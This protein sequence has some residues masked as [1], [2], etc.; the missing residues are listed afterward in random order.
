MLEIPLREGDPMTSKHVK[1]LFPGTL[2]STEAWKCA[3][4]EATAAEQISFSP[5]YNYLLTLIRFEKK[6][7]PFILRSK[8]SCYLHQNYQNPVA[9]NLYLSILAENIFNESQHIVTLTTV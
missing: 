5:T 9:E 2:Q 4:P 8:P 1:A 6:K 3:L 7:N